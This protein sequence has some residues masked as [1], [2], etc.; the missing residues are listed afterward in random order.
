MEFNFVSLAKHRFEGLLIDMEKESCEK[1]N[2]ISSRL[3]LNIR[4]E[5]YF[6]KKENINPI[7]DFAKE[8]GNIGVLSLDI[9]G[10]D[11]WILKE[12]Y[13][14]IKP[15]VIVTEYNA[16]FGLRNISVEYKDNFN[17]H[18]EHHSGFHHGASIMAFGNLLKKDYYLIKNIRGLNLI[19][20]RKDKLTDKRKILNLK[21]AYQEQKLRNKLSHSNANK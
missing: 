19:F 21:Q 8:K 17:R 3:G 20:I 2:E 4:G 6:I 16:S 11:Y 1:I 15:E 5:N 9:D 13:S 12:I 7:I 10:N 18:S 14:Q